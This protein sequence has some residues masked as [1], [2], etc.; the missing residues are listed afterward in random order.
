MVFVT[1][2]VEGRTG[3]NI[4]QYLAAKLI[5]IHYGHDYIPINNI[6]GIS[7]KLT[8]LMLDEKHFARKELENLV[9]INEKNM[10]IVLSDRID[11]L[12]DKDIVC[13]GYFQKSHYYIPY[14]SKLLSE[15]KS[16]N[17]YW[18]DDKNQIILVKNFLY[19]NHKQPITPDDIVLSLRLDD[20]LHYKLAKTTDVLPQQYY[21]DILE[22]E[23]INNRIL[24]IV[25]DKLKQD[26]E[27][28]YVEVFQKW[29][30]VMVS[31]DILSDFAIMRDSS[32][33]IHSNS[34]LCWLASFFVKKKKFV[35]FR[36]QIFM[37]INY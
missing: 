25:S 17:D 5:S 29:N 13:I 8:Q 2:L 31:E 28:R 23:M 37:K 34:T 10:E 26:W 33:L 1:F 16:S 35:I 36:E 18:I 19:C 3:N 7:D 12:K 9:I 6:P 24:Y 30:P 27:N 21:L 20:F 14:R 15:I 11:I 4:F 32:L 22:K